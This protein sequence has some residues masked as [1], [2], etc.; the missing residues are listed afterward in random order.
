M[1][2]KSVIPHKASRIVNDDIALGLWRRHVSAKEQGDKP[3]MKA[4][5]AEIQDNKYPVDTKNEILKRMMSDGS[6]FDGYNAAMMTLG[7]L[8]SICLYYTGQIL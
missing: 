7:Y 1:T 8:R 3:T 5:L 6:G 4:L 2:A